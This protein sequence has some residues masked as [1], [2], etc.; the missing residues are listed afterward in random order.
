VT[1]VFN[2]VSG[3]TNA[4]FW[5][6]LMNYGSNAVSLGK[7]HSSPRCVHEYRI[8]V[9]LGTTL[10][11]GGISRAVEQ[12]AGFYLAGSK[13]KLFLF[14]SNYTEAYDGYVLKKG[15]RATFTRRN[16]NVVGAQSAEPQ[17]EQSFLWFTRTG[18]QR[19]HV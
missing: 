15:P 16:G 6:E 10:N 11:P 5:V 9:P 17:R 8:P 3:T 2:E 14:A 19:D 12:H 7:L 1:V 4:V 13:R 18:D